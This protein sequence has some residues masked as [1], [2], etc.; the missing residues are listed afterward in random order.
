MNAVSALERL[1]VIEQRLCVRMN[2]ASRYRALVWLMRLT[3]RLGD[4][5]FWYGLMLALVLTYRAAA[6]ETV[7]RMIVTGLVCVALYK[8][9]KVR[10]SRPRPFEVHS[11]VVCVGRPLDKFSFPS[12]HTMHAVAFSIVALAYFPALWFALVPF[13][14]L[15]ALSRVVLGLHYP[16][17]VVA[18]AA[19]GT[20]V[21]STV[22]T[23]I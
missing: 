14:C 16:S 3:S 7:L 2:R 17:D 9:L 22:V 11:D 1:G 10:I 6:I 23:L 21:A 4:G 5:F 15:I 19:L 8:F 18:G 13:A 12:G 20:A